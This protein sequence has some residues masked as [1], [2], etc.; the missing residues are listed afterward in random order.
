[1]PSSVKYKLKGLKPYYS[2]LVRLGSPVVEVKTTAGSF[3]WQLDENTSQTF[4]RGSYEPYMQEAFRKLVKPG[5]TVYDIGANVGF[6]TLLLS[7]LV[8]PK[9]QV[10]AFEPNPRNRVSIQRQ[11]EVNEVKN[12]RVMDCALADEDGEAFLNTSISSS[13]GFVADKGQFGI[14]LRKLD[15]LELNLPAPNL[16]KIDVEGFEARVVRGAL[17][18]IRKNLPIVICDQNDEET[19]PSLVD[20]L[21]GLNYEVT[22]DWPIVLEPKSLQPK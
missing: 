2:R 9:G 7:H 19:K 20:V 13:Q 18:T 11:I 3:K 5:F 14:V 22:D 10:I 6:H 17:E 15:S 1:M 8:G 16:L 4:I 12:I 21:S